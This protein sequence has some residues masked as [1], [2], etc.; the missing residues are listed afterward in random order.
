MYGCV[1]PREVAGHTEGMIAMI[2]WLVC[3]VWCAAGFRSGVKGRLQPSVACLPYSKL[4]V[5]RF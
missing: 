4:A 5:L 1:V 2:P 3:A